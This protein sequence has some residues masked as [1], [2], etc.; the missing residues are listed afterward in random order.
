M[1]DNDMRSYQTLRR[2]FSPASLRGLLRFWMMTVSGMILI[3]ALPG[4]C[5]GVGTDGS[6][7]SVMA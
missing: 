1:L 7:D 2:N 3:V 4:F 5:A 6:A